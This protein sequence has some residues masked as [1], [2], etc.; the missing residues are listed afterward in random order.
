MC[1]TE[2]KEEQL[3]DSLFKSSSFPEACCCLSQSTLRLNYFLS[4]FPELALSLLSIG[5]FMLLFHVHQA[6]MLAF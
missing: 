2:G 4:R 5:L 3:N 6:Y 1:N